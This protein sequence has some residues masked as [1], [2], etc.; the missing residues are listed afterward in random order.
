MEEGNKYSL[1]IVDKQIEE[2]YGLKGAKTTT[3]LWPPNPIVSTGSILR[4]LSIKL[5]TVKWDP[6]KLKK[7]RKEPFT[8]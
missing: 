4:F 2:N 5:S 6:V 1:M 3:E 7:N 8:N